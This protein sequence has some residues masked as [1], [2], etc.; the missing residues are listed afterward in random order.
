M[1]TTTI[2]TESGAGLRALA[3]LAAALVLL[4][5]LLVGGCTSDEPNLVGTG[6]V[7]DRIDSV[8]VPLGAG[9]VTR[10][11]SLKVTNPKVLVHQQEVIYVGEQGGTRGGAILANFDFGFEFTEEYPETLFTAE[12]IKNVKYS[13]KK[14]SVLRGSKSWTISRMIKK[15][16]LK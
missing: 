1:K 11:S 5:A 7:T 2:G 14:L 3:A 16:G 15:T 4:V 10:F 13:L 8:L 6:L 12:N 9:D